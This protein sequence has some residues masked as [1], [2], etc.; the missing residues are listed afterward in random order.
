MEINH[1]YYDEHVHSVQVHTARR[2]KISEK[3]QINLRKGTDHNLNTFAPET[4]Y[5]TRPS[6]S[7]L[8]SSASNE[9]HSDLVSGLSGTA[10]YMLQA[11]R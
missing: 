10:S 3:A 11:D 9:S 8:L 5:L 7:T 6:I 4:E 1:Y 2:Y